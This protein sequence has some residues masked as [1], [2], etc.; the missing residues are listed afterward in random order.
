[1]ASKSQIGG[2]L[3]KAGIISVKTLERALEMQKGSGKRLGAFLKEMGLVTEEEVIEAL[4][5]QCGL[6][7]VRN[8]ADQHLPRE[9]L[10]LV[11]AQ[12]AVERLIFP[13]KGREGM[14]TIATLDPFDHATFD[15]LAK[16]TG[17]QINLALATRDD[18]FAA[19]GKHYL[20][21]KP[22]D[23]SRRKILLLDPS[24]AVTSF[25]K[26]DME[27]E[28]FEVIFAHDGIDGL[29]LAFSR[30]PDIVVC[31]L[32][33]PRMD[34]YHFMRALKAHPEM[35]DIPVILMSVRTSTDE[36][37]RALKAGFVDFIGKPAMPVRVLARIER[38]LSTAKSGRHIPP[39]VE[40]P[41]RSPRH[42]AGL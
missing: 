24:P 23:S 40:M 18:I 15:H 29:K 16:E 42:R 26:G 39:P 4:A 41:R 34:G 20:K 33:M 14:L 10:D 25:L 5:T 32:M 12:L 2:L 11:P 1:M 30:H 13:L 8:F 28:G 21:E 19:I 9:L 17:M 6:R 31:D 22:A 36:E 38:A 35:A 3:V 7:T 27:K 37:H